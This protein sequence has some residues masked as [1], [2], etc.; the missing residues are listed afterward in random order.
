MAASD[1]LKRIV[2]DIPY[3]FKDVVSYF[4]FATA[5][6]LILS[7]A[8][9]WYKLRDF[10]GPWVASFSEFWLFRKAI[11]GEMHLHLADVCAQY[12]DS[13]VRV[14]PNELVT[15]DPE[16]GRHMS[17]TRLKHQK[18]QWY[19]SLKVDPYVDN[20]FSELDPDKHDKI[21]AQ[22]SSAFTLKEN[23]H[24]MTKIDE[25]ISL[26]VDLIERKYIS[27]STETKPMD[28]ALVSQYFS[29][30]VITS[31]VFGHPFGYLAEDKDIYGYVGTINQMLPFVS[32]CSATPTLGRLFNMK[33]IQTLLG[34]S[35]KDKDGPGKLMAMAQQ[36][37]GTRFGAEKETKDDML[38]SFLSHGMA[39]RQAESEIL[40]QILA[41]SDTTSTAVRAIFLFIIT[42][43]NVHAKLLAEIDSAIQENQISNPITD[44]QAKKLQY[45]QA[46]IKEGLRIWPPF[47]GMLMKKVNPGG[48]MIKGQFVPGGTSIGHCGWGMQRGPE[49]GHDVNVFRPERWLEA[50]AEQKIQMEKTVDIIFGS[51][52]WAC[53]GKMIVYVEL[54]KIFVELLRRFEFAVVDPDKVWNSRNF[55]LFL[56][57][58]MWL[59]ITKRNK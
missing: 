2:T 28:F 40:T 33:W 44:E 50:D 16:I 7:Y 24:L 8:K 47:T 9:S 1:F 54:N 6:T 22:I 13:L 26:F 39:K 48:E 29:L 51:G 37:V 58:K 52:R 21:R 20:I 27:T 53:L 3:S 14:G 25:S 43:P 56:Q 34:P 12:G 11:T 10:K 19:A 23:P 32:V 35:T 36:Y 4:I 55:T 38:G 31:I 30:D 45:L 5:V 17:S 46:V 59:R 15:S 18:A 49:F 41:G 42:N 57:N